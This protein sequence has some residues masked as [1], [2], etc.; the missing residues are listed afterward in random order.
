MKSSPAPASALGSL[1]PA[2][3]PPALYLYLFPS[4]STALPVRQSASNTGKTSRPSVDRITI[5]G[6]CFRSQRIQ[7]SASGTVKKENLADDCHQAISRLRLFAR[8]DL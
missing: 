5:L 6:R 4:S 7:L 3:A 8:S 1:P 2:F